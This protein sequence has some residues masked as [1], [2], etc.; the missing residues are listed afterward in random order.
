MAMLDKEKTAAEILDLLSGVAKAA[1][2]KDLGES[3]RRVLGRT[4]A[5]VKAWSL[6]GEITGFGLGPRVVQDQFT[7]QMALRIYVRHKRPMSELSP[8]ERIPAELEL[9]G[10]D[11][12]VPIDVVQ[13]DLPELDGLTG[14]NRPMFPSIS[15]GHCRSRQTGS[16]GIFCRRSSEPLDLQM[17]SNA[18]VLA[19]SGQ[20]RKGDAIIQPGSFHGGTCPVKTVANLNT[21]VPLERGGGFPNQV[22]AALARV[23]P[24]L[25]VIRH[26]STPLKF[27]KKSHVRVGD[28]VTRFGSN[29][30]QFGAIF[31]L[32]FRTWMRFRTPLG[33]AI[34]GFRDLIVYTAPSLS[35]DSGG[36]IIDT[37]RS[38]V[39]LHMGR[40][41]SRTVGCAIWNIQ[42]K[43]TDLELVEELP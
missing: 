25:R 8:G 9:E 34:F 6:A 15:V 4:L 42:N 28:R 1:D 17:L 14:T 29:G 16:I 22:D 35:G 33:P 30:H 12:L 23:K 24:G 3:S 10:Y 19:V 21:F 36:P 37:N 41:G 27:A 18:H 2:R 39:G 43:W 40:V 11:D 5:R 31:D 7:D 38:L 32:D 20:A 13:Q 26:P